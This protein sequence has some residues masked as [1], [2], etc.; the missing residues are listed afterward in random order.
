MGILLIA[1]R[2]T[3]KSFAGNIIL[4]KEE[5]DL[6]RCAQCVRRRGEVA[7]RRLTVIEVPGWFREYSVDSS[8]ELLKQEVVLSVSLCPPGPH[9]ILLLIRVDIRF[10]EAQRKT[11]QG[12]LELL[13]EGVWSHT[14]VVF[15]HGNYLL[16]ASIEQHIESEGQDLQ[17]LL[18]KC[19][20]RYHVLN[21]QDR[22]DDTQVK[23][24]LEMIE[25]TV[26]QNNGCHFEID[27]KILQEM[28]ERRRAEEERANER[29]KRMKKQRDDIRSQM[30]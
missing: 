5:F 19:G 30:S 6:K 13:G 10:T 14:I 23:E 9:A 2:N 11:V 15:L 4:G 29:M 17:W 16:D 22:S 21:F 1:P 24:L 12:H 28:K 18:D 8:P 3:G 7:N 27:K 26:A 25:E 20:N